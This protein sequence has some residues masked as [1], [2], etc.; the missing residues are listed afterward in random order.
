MDLNLDIDF[1][2]KG[3]LNDAEPDYALL[4][5]IALQF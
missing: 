1:G 2:V 3:G 4:T 5:G